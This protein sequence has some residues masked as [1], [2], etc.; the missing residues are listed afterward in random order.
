MRSIILFIGLFISSNALNFCF[1]QAQLPN[2]SFENW[3]PSGIETPVGWT[4]SNFSVNFGGRATA[5]KTNNSAK[6]N[7]AVRVISDTITIPP[8][9]GTGVQTVVSGFCALGILNQLIRGGAAYTDRPRNF[10]A[11]VKGTV[12]QGDSNV[13][14]I[15]LS[16]FIDS[17]ETSQIIARASYDQ[18]T[19]DTV[20]KKITVP[21]TY[22]T[23]HKP[24]SITVQIGAGGGLNSFSIARGNEFFVDEILME[25]IVAPVKDI[26]KNSLEVRVAPNPVHEHVYF[27]WDNPTNQAFDLVVTNPQGQIVHRQ[28]Q[29]TGTQWVLNRKNIPSGLY[30][31][32]FF[33]D[34][35]SVYTGK[36][37]FK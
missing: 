30:F 27:E 6:G 3:S 28:T 9:F 24:D 35:Q 32:Q 36:L 10:T 21:F 7:F 19:T 2:N 37:V 23:G 20:Y 26:E 11:W 17:T 16:R 12:V 13:I 18:R 5:S 33:K 8:P 22:L 34:Q 15:T 4:T 1:A 14:L 25:G 29:M 31:F